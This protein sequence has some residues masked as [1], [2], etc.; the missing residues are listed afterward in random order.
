MSGK[1]ERIEFYT[2]KGHTKAVTDLAWRADS[3]VLAS[4]SEDGQIILWEMNEGKQVK[5]WDAH[6]GGVLSVDFAPDGKL[7][8]GGR[9]KTVKIW[10]PDGS[11]LRTIT[12]SDDIV[13]AVGVHP[14][15]KAGHLR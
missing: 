8:S 15:F 3:N 4:C 1:A 6:G 2:L 5:K 9:D 7:V 14:G 10:K 13:M 12:A 11:A